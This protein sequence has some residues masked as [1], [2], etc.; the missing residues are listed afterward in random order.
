MGRGTWLNSRKSWVSIQEPSH[1]NWQWRLWTE[2]NSWKHDFDYCQSSSLILRKIFF[3]CLVWKWRGFTQVLSIKSRAFHLSSSISLGKTLYKTTKNSV[4]Q[5]FIC[6][7]IQHILMDQ[8]TNC[9]IS[10]LS[11]ALPSTSLSCVNETAGH[12]WKKERKKNSWEYMEGKLGFWISML[13]M[14]SAIPDKFNWQLSS[15]SVSLPNL[16]IPEKYHAK[17]QNTIDSWYIN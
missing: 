12:T 17:I 7:G 15:T 3:S 5:F 14:G 11:E 16:E 10:A 8:R 13:L 9:W 6:F 2:K 1:L 4:L